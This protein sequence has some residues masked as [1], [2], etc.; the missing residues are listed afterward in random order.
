MKNQYECIKCRTTFNK[1]DVIYEDKYNQ[2]I[3]SIACP[4]CKGKMRVIQIPKYLDKF[5]YINNDCKYYEY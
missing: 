2:K 1:Y 4:Y 3:R 5:L